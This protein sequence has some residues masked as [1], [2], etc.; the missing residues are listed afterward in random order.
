MPTVV[1][2]IVP[3]VTPTVEPTIAPTVEPTVVP[4]AVPTVEPT[5]TGAPTPEPTVEVT[6]TPESTPEPKPTP[7]PEVTPTPSPEATPTPEVTPTPTAEPTPTPTPESTPTPAP[8]PTPTPEATPT[9]TPEPTP[10][11]TPEATPTPTPTPTATPEPDNGGTPAGDLAIEIDYTQDP[12]VLIGDASSIPNF[13]G[14]SAVTEPQYQNTNTGS[15]ALALDPSEIYSISSIGNHTN[16]DTRWASKDEFRVEVDLYLPSDESDEKFMFFKYHGLSI[17]ELSTTD[18][19]SLYL[20]GSSGLSYRWFKEGESVI[21]FNTTSLSFPKDRY[22]KFVVMGSVAGDLPYGQTLRVEVYDGDGTWLWSGGDNLPITSFVAEAIHGFTVG[23]DTSKTPEIYYKRARVFRNLETSWNKRNNV[24]IIALQDSTAAAS[25]HQ[26]I[27]SVVGDS[28][29]ERISNVL[30]VD[31]NPSGMSYEIL[32]AS[33]TRT[34]GYDKVGIELSEFASEAVIMQESHAN[35]GSSAITHR[36]HVADSSARY[37]IVCTGSRAGSDIAS[38]YTVGGSSKS[39]NTSW[40]RANAAVFNNVDASA[41]YIDIAF[42]GV[43]A[44]IEIQKLDD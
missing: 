11:P 27:N 14:G 1:P 22:I 12:P 36:L 31:G 18:S 42:I 7:T 25:I 17:P 3:T 33:S 21:T 29:G 26:I 10:T 4:T 44:A 32:D 30:E 41:G 23:N 43:L 28:T 2:T 40:N 34:D 24:A 5:P 19:A 37:R 15:T 38:T 39:I 8:T 9:P 20:N 6:P 35:T 16:D 13:K